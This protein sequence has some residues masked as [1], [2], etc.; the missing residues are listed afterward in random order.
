MQ[1]DLD[2]K[3]TNLGTRVI[4]VE[5][6]ESLVI[7]PNPTQDRFWIQGAEGIVPSYI[8][9]YQSNGTKIVSEE[10]LDVLAN[11]YKEGFYLGVLSKGIYLVEMMIKGEIVHQ[12]LSVY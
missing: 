2:G 3:Q 7:Y 4:N 12:K 5:S 9:I 10:S 1:E 6:D 11:I 8:H